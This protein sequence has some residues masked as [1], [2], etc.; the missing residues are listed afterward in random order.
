MH[1]FAAPT[2]VCLCPEFKSAWLVLVTQ[3]CCM[4]VHSLYIYCT[5]ID[6]ADNTSSLMHLVH[7]WSTTGSCLVTGRR[8]QFLLSFIYKAIQY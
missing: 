1:A 6:G 4:H 5:I 2:S 3:R 7:Y 8:L